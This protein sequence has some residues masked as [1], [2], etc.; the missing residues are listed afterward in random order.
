[1]MVVEP[2]IKRR[3]WIPEMHHN[4]LIHRCVGLASGYHG[5]NA[6]VYMAYI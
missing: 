3:R 5:G 1:M 6:Y 4:D 2:G